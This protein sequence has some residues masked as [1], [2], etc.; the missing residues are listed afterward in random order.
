MTTTP[1]RVLAA[2][3]QLALVASSTAAQTSP[4]ATSA[5]TPV[6]LAEALAAGTLDLGLRLFD[7][8][9][10][11]EGDS[12]LVPRSRQKALALGATVGYQSRPWHGLSVGLAGSTS[13]PLVAEP[14]YDGTKLLAPGQQGY[15]VL[16]IGYLQLD[17][18][19]LTARAYRQKLATPLITS[20][21]LRMT[22]VTFEALTVEGRPSSALS[23]IVSHVTGYKAAN[24]TTFVSA[25]EAGGLG[26]NESV[27]L[28]GAT[29]KPGEAVALQLWDYYSWNLMNAPYLQLDLGTGLGKEWR[30]TLSLQGL[31]QQ[32]V[33]DSLAG[34]IRTGFGAGQLAFE[35][36]GFQFRLAASKVS[37][38]GEILYPWGQNPSFTASVEEDQD[39]P[40]EI[41][42]AW[43]F[44]WP[45][46]NVGVP[47]LKVMIDRTKA[48]VQHPL[49]GMSN[50]D[51][52]ESQAIVDY[53]FSGA[54]TGLKVRLFGAWVESSLSS[55]SIYGQDY[56]D[57]RLI[58]NYRAET[59]VRR[60]LGLGRE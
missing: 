28:A 10:L 1:L 30:A 55:G 59:T 46:E 13:Q 6:P 21:D 57:L 32:N 9:R 22:P 54:L 7:F 48:R 2:A 14:E 60:L 49:L 45:L 19:W 25:S 31:W 20:L 41:A 12:V 8:D 33:G 35:H 58:V 38:Y 11:F 36:R 51:Q 27:T 37:R 23:F 50:K 26:G 39:L 5:S 44:V 47:G 17:A 24:S 40:G 53:A 42:W 56:R 29:W 15:A 18:G 52:W 3:I 43:G 34:E 16:H 4:P